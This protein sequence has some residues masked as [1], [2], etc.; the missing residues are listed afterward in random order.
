MAGDRATCYRSVASHT[1]RRQM[2]GLILPEI[3]QR[4]SQTLGGVSDLLRFTW[5]MLREMYL[6]TERPA[7]F[8]SWVFSL[9]CMASGQMRLELSAKGAFLL[10]P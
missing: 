2:A 7:G 6:V 3:P 1:E 8:L 4:K 9:P 5:I 10:A